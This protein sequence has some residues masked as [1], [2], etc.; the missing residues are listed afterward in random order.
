M[1]H[2]LVDAGLCFGALTFDLHTGQRT[3]WEVTATL[4]KMY[5]VAAEGAS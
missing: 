3:R 4:R 2:L 1:S 5:V